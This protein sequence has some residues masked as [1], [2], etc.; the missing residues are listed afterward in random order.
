MQGLCMLLN[1]IKEDFNI[2]IRPHVKLMPKITT[3]ID[4]SNTIIYKI[5]CKDT[6][7]Q[8][9]YVG[10]TTNF[11][12]RKHA[13][14]QSCGNPKSPNHNCKL[15]TI[16]R[17]NGGWTSWRMEIVNFF[18]CNNQCEARIKEQ[19]YFISLNATLNS[20]EPMPSPK[21]KPPV[22]IVHIVTEMD[23]TSGKFMCNVCDFKCN[24]ES[25]WHRHLATSKHKNR[26]NLVPTNVKEYACN[27]GNK[28]K[29][30]SSLWNHHRNC[31][32]TPQTISDNTCNNFISD[33]E[34]LMTVL[35]QNSEIIKENS[36]L[37]HIMLEVIKTVSHNQP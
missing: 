18:N 27:C 12:Q 14:K 7:V 26:T 36:E 28:Y 32:C 34:L 9:L 29:H 22:K 20:V 11:V 19:E 5:M 4:Y 15:Y 35:K 25:D 21:P 17:E 30:A 3:E 1:M 33:K 8:E 23:E 31:M 37:K 13:H 24:K 10:H 16:I 2:K 6:S